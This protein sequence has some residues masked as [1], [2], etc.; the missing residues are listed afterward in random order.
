MCVCVCVCVCVCERERE[1]ERERMR[2]RERVWVRGNERVSERVNE[3]GKEKRMVGVHDLH[4]SKATTNLNTLSTENEIRA[5]Q[6][7][8]EP[9]THCIRGKCSTN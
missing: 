4:Q 7:R 3:E 1:S 9:T 6:V 2:E 5:A 8:F